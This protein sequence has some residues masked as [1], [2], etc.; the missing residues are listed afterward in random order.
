M[1]PLPLTA[2]MQAVFRRI[3]GYDWVLLAFGMS[4]ARVWRLV[5][6]RVK[7]RIN[8]AGVDIHERNTHR[9]FVWELLKAFRSQNRRM[10]SDP[11]P[12]LTRGHIGS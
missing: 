5:Q 1:R 4:H 6:T 2:E 11:P 12:R 3:R 8:A 7:N 10:T 9:S